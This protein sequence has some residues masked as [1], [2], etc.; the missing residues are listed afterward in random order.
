M[1]NL[2]RGSERTKHTIWMIDDPPLSLSGVSLA[3]K[4]TMRHSCNNRVIMVMMLRIKRCSKLR[5]YNF[6]WLGG[7]SHKC[8]AKR[9]A[10]WRKW[11]LVKHLISR[12]SAEP[13]R[14]TIFYK[15]CWQVF[16]ILIRSGAN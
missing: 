5:R 6:V 4:S 15:I 11:S 1:R 14:N 2:I 13:N 8:I 16:H 10:V 12:F 3:K 7:K 9:P